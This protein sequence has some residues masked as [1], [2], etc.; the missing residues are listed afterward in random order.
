VI[1][2][3]QYHVLQCHPIFI[4][5]LL[6]LRSVLQCVLQCALQCDIKTSIS[7]PIQHFRNIFFGIPFLWIQKNDSITGVFQKI[8]T[9]LSDLLLRAGSDL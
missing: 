6:H 8:K 9:N 7:C 5:N 2:N 3:P 4:Y 1:S